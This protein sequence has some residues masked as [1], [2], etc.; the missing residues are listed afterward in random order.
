M[1]SEKLAALGLGGGGENT[2]TTN[3]S[4]WSPREDGRMVGMLRFGAVVQSIAARKEMELKSFPA[5]INHK[6][7]VP[8]FSPQT[9][10]LG[11]GHFF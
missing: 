9:Q 5:V 7:E 3:V 4:R 8:Q 1:K 6:K 10:T 2:G 11:S